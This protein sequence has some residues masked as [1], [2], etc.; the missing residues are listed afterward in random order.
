M[1]ILH[2][3]A[4]PFPTVQGT[5]AAVRAMIE[6]EHEAELGPELLTYPRSG[7]ALSAD[8][9]VHRVADLSRDRSLRSGP[10]W[11]K[12][13]TDAQLVRATRRLAVTRAVCR[14]MAHHV[15]AAAAAWTAGA[16]PLVF[17]AHTA[18][19]PELPTYLPRSLPHRAERWV[20]RAGEALDVALA[21]RADAVVAVAPRLAERLGDASGRIVA[22]VPVPWS[23]PPP[24]APSER[25]EARRHLALDPVAPVLLYAGNL[26]AY[27]GLELLLGALRLVSERREDARLLVATASDPGSL[28][29]Q[30]RA[31]GLAE[32]LVLAPL[33]DEPERRRA[34]AAAD[35]VV[36]PRGTEGGLPIKLLD[37]LARGV[38]TVVTRRAAAGL[39][40]EG[41]ALV[42]RDDDV[43]GLAAAALIA[44]QARETSAA[45]GARGPQYI[46]R[47]H[48]PSA[49]LAALEAALD[50][51]NAGSRRGG[52]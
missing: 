44:V 6:A 19:G 50:S 27:Q 17:V 29:A 30:A 3:A 13:V 15:E 37:A 46:R 45:L 41:T 8:W 48:A 14:V 2:V 10:S 21:Q 7:Y 12:L 18:L 31:G 39:A 32:R 40:L 26:D 1:S 38:P 52:P 34:H 4:M 20:R 16:R 43:D 11:R 23:C 28:L 33:R 24:L 36:V 25:I 35:V 42:T 9:A 5:Q 51:V 49:Y 22:Y 47:A